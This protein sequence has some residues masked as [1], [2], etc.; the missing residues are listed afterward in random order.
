[1]GLLDIFEAPFEAIADI[2]ESIFDGVGKLFDGVTEFAG[3][4]LNNDVFK[5]VAIAGAAVFTA[6]AAAGAFGL[7]T[8]TGVLG[9]LQSNAITSGIF[10]AGASLGSGA[11]SAFGFGSATAPATPGAI[12]VNGAGV[13]L[14][15]TGASTG[16]GSGG[17]L[18]GAGSGSA[19]SGA[20]GSPFQFTGG[21][22]GGGAGPANIAGTALRSPGASLTKSAGDLTSQALAKGVNSGN[23]FGGGATAGGNSAAEAGKGLLSQIGGYAGKAL[24]GAGKLGTAITNNPGNALLAGN[25]LSSA[26][27]PNEEDLEREREKQQIAAENRARGRDNRYGVNN[28]TGESIDLSSGLDGIRNASGNYFKGLLSQSDS[29]SRSAPAAA[30][31]RPSVNQEFEYQYNPQSGRIERTRVQMA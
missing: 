25:V 9:T 5:I 8:T 2:G 29:G 14:A 21:A 24:E 11:A 27:G 30:P 3:E 1:M 13:K 20:A 15:G 16:A 4:L 22:T 31:R 10:N 23:V 6:G 18:S 7:S 28:L 12:G 17:V 26:F 19:F